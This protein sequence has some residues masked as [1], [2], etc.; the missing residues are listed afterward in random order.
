MARQIYQNLTTY[1]MINQMTYSCPFMLKE[2]MKCY[3]TFISGQTCPKSLIL[4]DIFLFA[5]FRWVSVF[6]TGQII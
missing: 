4:T 6:V 1:G 5:H 3:I 2:F